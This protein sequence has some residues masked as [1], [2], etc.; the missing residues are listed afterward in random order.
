MNQTSRFPPAKLL[1]Y[2][3]A[4]VKK[5]QGSAVEGCSAKMPQCLADIRLI[6][7]FTSRGQ[8]NP[9]YLMKCGNGAKFVLRKKPAGKLLKGAHQVQ[10]E[11]VIMKQL[12]SQSVGSIPVPFPVPK[13][14]HCCEDE[15]VI[16]TDFFI[17]EFVEGRIY[18]NMNMEGLEKQQIEQGDHKK[19]HHP[20]NSH[21]HTLSHT[22][23][24]MLQEM[25]HTLAHLHSIDYTKI[26]LSS[27]GRTTQDP[28]DYFRRQIHVWTRQYRHAETHTIDAVNKLIDW[29]G[30]GENIPTQNDP[31][32]NRHTIVHGDYKVDNIC[33]EKFPSTKVAAVLDWEL[34][35]IGHPMAD[36]A[37]FCL[38]YHL[39][40]SMGGMDHSDRSQQLTTTQNQVIDMYSKAVGARNPVKSF[41]FYVVFSIF[42]LVGIVQGVY[43]RS[44][45]GNA[46]SSRARALGRLVEPM[47]EV[48]WQMVMDNDEHLP[49][50]SGGVSFRNSLSFENGLK[51]KLIRFMREHVYPAESIYAKQMEEYGRAWKELPII[52]ELKSKAKAVGLW[53]LFLPR[54][55]PHGAGL[56]NLEY[57]S[58][59][60]EMGKVL[61]SA[62]VFNCNAPDSGNMEL[63]EMFGSEEQKEKY[64]NP[65]L[66]G[67]VRS[68]FS[69]TEPAVASSDARNIECRIEKSGDGSSYVVNGRKWYIT[70]AG[71]PQCAFSI[72]MGKTDPNADAYR[73]Q[74]MI[75]VPMDNPGVKVERAMD[76]F[77]HYD[78]PFGHC[79]V[80]FTNV[81]V[82][83]KNILGG[84]GRGFELAQK[85]LGPGRI[86][87]CAR[88][89]GFTQ[90]ALD[91]TCERAQ[92]RVAFGST[93]S[94]NPLIA[95]YI[96]Q[97]EIE[98]EQARLLVTK[99]AH[100]IDLY[101]NKKC[102]S[103]IAQIKIAV[104]QM[105][106]RVIDRCMQIFGAAGLSR[107]ASGLPDWYVAARSLR[108][109]D[110][111]DEVHMH[112]V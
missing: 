19:G 32:F 87:H 20:V 17:M 57:M 53:N 40:A 80:S 63:L 68:C 37:Y 56:S 33:F 103:L 76:V 49:M 15:N 59:A 23:N 100:D 9:S 26:G 13:M 98:L 66:S 106:C 74:T 85:R 78:E 99:C 4:V 94:K 60:E 101:G 7:Q 77:G 110:G 55:S 69:M 28:N 86:H 36:L 27:Y 108:V 48:A 89:I 8:S 91:R 30:N 16:G 82:P 104:P 11:Y 90:R 67:E 39:P 2:L 22:K 84:E 44:L 38:F 18:D 34:S 58:L 95:S 50:N 52:E 64:L 1:S 71:H 61:W 70:G 111:P 25:V 12:G 24:R 51:K 3:D 81:R 107:Q 83:A 92:K 102:R 65:L 62:Q 6:E 31:K 47:A 73:Q 112:T 43:K 93:L 88:C 109:A 46:S 42:R 10:R 54:D 35:T 45:Q 75:I 21:Q 41:Y 97:S 29:L 72:V 79:V 14:I 96:A 105:S 5:E